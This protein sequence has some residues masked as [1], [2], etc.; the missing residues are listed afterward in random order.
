MASILV[1]LATTDLPLN[2]QY[3]VLRF[4]RPKRAFVTVVAA[5]SGVILANGVTV[6]DIRR[7]L[8]QTGIC[9]WDFF[10]DVAL[11]RPFRLSSMM[12]MA[13]CRHRSALTLYAVAKRMFKQQ[14]IEHVN[15]ISFVRK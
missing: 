12:L 3:R 13:A 15:N 6:R 2:L 4:C 5:G 9:Q 14:Y 11:I 7:Q 8:D 1:F 10:A